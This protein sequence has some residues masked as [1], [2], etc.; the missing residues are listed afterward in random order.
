MSAQ[1]IN[2]GEENCPA[3]PSENQIC[4]LP[5]VSLVLCHVS[6]PNLGTLSSYTAQLKVLGHPLCTLYTYTD[7]HP[8]SV[9]R[10]LYTQCIQTTIHTVKTDY[11]T[12][13]VYK[14]PY[15]Q[16][17]QTTIY[18]VCTDHCKY[19][20][21]RP[22]CKHS[23]Y[24]PLCRHIVYR[25][26]QTHSYADHH[27]HNSCTQTTLYTVCTDHSLNTV[28]TDHFIHTIIQTTTHRVYT[29]HF[30]HSY[31]DHHTQCKQTTLNTKLYRPPYT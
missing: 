11:H 21:H 14:P 22:F 20:V 1:K 16:C 19:S 24:I 17:I 13:S 7:R 4:K 9:Y 23:V 8:H 12:H 15:T 5:F 25:P 2:W 6:N 29:Y 27:T 30:I 31:T 10:P 26:L 28:Y 18:T 3:I